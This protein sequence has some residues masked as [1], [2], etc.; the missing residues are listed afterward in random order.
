MSLLDK[1][2]LSDKLNFDDLYNTFVG[3]ERRQQIIFVSAASLIVILMLF[4]PAGCVSSKLNEKQ[5][6]YEDYTSMASEFYAVLTE[7][8]DLKRGFGDLEKSVSRLGNDSLSK[9]IYNL[10]E[11]MGIKKSSVSLKSISTS[12]SDLFIEE[13]KQATIK[14]IKFDQMVKLIEQLENYSDLPLNIKKLTAKVDP[15][16]KQIMRSLSFSVT[17]IKPKK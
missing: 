11:E 14:N 8:A 3:L 6:E 4:I 16:N 10:S 2:N 12:S 9:V 15:K 1:L 13:G 7:Y 17:T 5:T